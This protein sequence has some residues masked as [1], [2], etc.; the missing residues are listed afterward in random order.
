MLRTPPPGDRSL[1]ED[2][3]DEM[4]ITVENIESTVSSVIRQRDAVLVQQLNSNFEILLARSLETLRTQLHA[5][6]I[7]SDSSTS[8]TPTHPLH[9]PQPYQP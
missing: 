3:I 9:G 1:D 4:L 8:V 2:F 7:P 5:S 6:A